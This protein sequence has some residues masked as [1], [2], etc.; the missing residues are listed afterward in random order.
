MYYEIKTDRL[1]LRPLALS[2]WATVHAYAGDEENTTYMLWLP[3]DTAEETKQFLNR[4]TDEWKKAVPDYYEFAIVFEGVQ[5]G[6]ISVALNDA[7]DTGE[8]GWVLN[9]RYWKRGIAAEAAFAIKEFALDVLKLRKLVA[10]CDSS[11]PFRRSDAETGH[12]AGVGHR[13]KDLSQ[14]RGDRAGAYLF[15]LR[16]LRCGSRPAKA[17]QRPPQNRLRKSG[18]NARKLRPFGEQATSLSASNLCNGCCF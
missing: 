16:F 6:A 17:P 2:D 8:L 4:V 7:R 13:H 12:D 14:K 11:P 10:H 1:L 15:A 9:K 3:N 5:V 18:G